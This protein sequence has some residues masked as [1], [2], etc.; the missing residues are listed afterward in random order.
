L[1]TPLG[2]ALLLGDGELQHRRS[3]GAVEVVEPD[4][5]GLAAI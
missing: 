3:G 5:E 1:Q 4:A 2:L